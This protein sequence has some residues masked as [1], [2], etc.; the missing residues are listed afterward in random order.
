MSTPME[1]AEQNPILEPA[2]HPPHDAS[3]EVSHQNCSQ[4]TIIAEQLGVGEPLAA[5]DPPPPPPA[6]TPLH[7]TKFLV[8]GTNDSPSLR[9]AARFDFNDYPHF[10]LR[11]VKRNKKVQWESRP[12]PNLKKIENNRVSPEHAMSTPMEIAGQ[13]PILEPAIHPPDD[14]SMELSHQNCSQP[15]IIAEQLGV[16]EPLAA[17]DPPPPLHETKFLVSGTNDSPSL[18]LAARFDFNDYPHL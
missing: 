3:M 9:L 10:D 2:I 12:F 16:A 14:A 18:R 1:I 17:T 13:N 5:T 7:E 15:T 4:P 8:S 11:P 6:P